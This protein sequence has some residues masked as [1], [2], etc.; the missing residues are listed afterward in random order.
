LNT[1]FRPNR[2]RKYHDSALANQQMPR[3]TERTRDRTQRL[4]H[5]RYPSDVQIGHGEVARE[6]GLESEGEREGEFDWVTDRQPLERTSQEGS[7][8]FL[9]LRN[10]T[11]LRGDIDDPTQ[12]HSL[13][14]KPE[15]NIEIYCMST[16]LGTLRD[17]LGSF[18]LILP[19]LD[20]GAGTETPPTSSPP[21]SSFHPSRRPCPR[22][23]KGSQQHLG[24]RSSVL[25]EAIRLRRSSRRVRR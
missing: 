2:L 18:P 15:K 20:V 6:Q 22:P 9:G 5:L 12:A 10:G 11:R 8:R 4:E 17:Q 14:T 25:C 1:P 13:R 16:M 7:E 3:H 21:A 23:R 19:I 24:S